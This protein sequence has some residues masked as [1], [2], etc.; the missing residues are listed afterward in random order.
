MS[1]VLI[2]ITIYT[3]TAFAYPTQYI[4][5]YQ[6]TSWPRQK[7][8]SDDEGKKAISF[9]NYFFSSLLTLLNSGETPSLPLVNIFSASTVLE[10]RRVTQEDPDNVHRSLEFTAYFTCCTPRAPHIKVA[11]CT[12]SPM[13]NLRTS[14]SVQ[15]CT[16]DI[17]PILL[18]EYGITLHYCLSSVICRDRYCGMHATKN[19]G[20]FCSL[21]SLSV[22]AKIS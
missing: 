14:T 17:I 11:L 12:T 1:H 5:L 16:P 15:Q 21:H 19:M 13:M 18:V 3:T 22:T 8:P 2:T 4:A 7:P 20:T 9:S 10:R 6:A